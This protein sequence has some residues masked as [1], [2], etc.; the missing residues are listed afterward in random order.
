MNLLQLVNDQ[1]K[2]DKVKIEIQ[3]NK[4]IDL[5]KVSAALTEKNKSQEEKTKELISQ[6]KTLAH[7]KW[8]LDSEKTR[9]IGAMIESCVWD[10][11]KELGGV[12]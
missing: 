1:Q 6:N 5:E 11:I 12:S 10:E 4:I 7:E 8:L 2:A 9:L 3:Q